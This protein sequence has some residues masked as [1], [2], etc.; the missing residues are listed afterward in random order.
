MT[1]PWATAPLVD[2]QTGE[3]FRIADVARHRPIEIGSGALLI[4]AA[5]FDLVDKWVSIRLTLGL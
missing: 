5:T 1:E 4:G 3:T 2:V